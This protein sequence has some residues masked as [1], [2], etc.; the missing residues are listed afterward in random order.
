MTEPQADSLRAL[1]DSTAAFY[2]RFGV[3]PTLADT[4]QNFQEE[5]QELIEA[6]RSASDR[7][8]IAEEAADVF[9]TALGICL[10]SGVDIDLL[11]QQVYAVIAKNDAKTQ[12]THVYH[13]GKIR[14]RA[15]RGPAHEGT[16]P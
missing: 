4:I 8:H 7:A 1:A 13:N 11:A 9:V 3:Q 10:A 12:A 15:S 5:V 6:A 2:A 14:R 16:S